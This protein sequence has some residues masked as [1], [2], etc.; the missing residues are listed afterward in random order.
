MPRPLAFVGQA[1]IYT[2][3]AIVIGYFS[4]R[5]LYHR[6]PD[7][8]AEIVVS[9]SHTGERVEP[10]RKLTREEIAELAANMRRSE[11][12][13]RERRPLE[14]ELI[15][16]DKNLFSDQLPPT[17]L[18][19]DGASQIHQRFTVPRGSHRLVARLRD[20][21]RSDGYD[22]EAETM[23]DLGPRERLV[24][25]FRPETGNFLFSHPK[26]RMNP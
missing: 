25:D 8:R 22:F 11:V 18:S 5:P 16:G 1:L 6:L 9:F 12:C 13:G 24:I 7:D 2:A 19:S 15:L 3:V 17:G 10:C 21:A 26:E 20:S 14:L 4:F 23:V